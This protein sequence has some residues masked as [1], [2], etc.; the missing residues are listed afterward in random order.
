[1]AIVINQYKVIKIQMNVS[2]SNGNNKLK[3]KSK[4]CKHFKSFDYI[5]A[6][7][8]FLLAILKLWNVK[9][10]VLLKNTSDQN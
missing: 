3:F 1:M 7:E 10:I 9:Q 2:Q 8:I 5:Q 6:S 4:Q